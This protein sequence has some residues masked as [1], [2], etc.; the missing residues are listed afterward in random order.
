MPTRERKKT[1][2]LLWQPVKLAAMQAKVAALVTGGGGGGGGG[3]GRA[4]DTVNN[5]DTD[6][7]PQHR[8]RA[9]SR[10]LADV[11]ANSSPIDFLKVSLTHYFMA[12]IVDFNKKY[13][14]KILEQA[15]QREARQMGEAV[16]SPRS[17]Y[18]QW[19]K[20][21]TDLNIP[22]HAGILGIAAEY[23]H[24]T[25]IVHPRLLE[26]GFCCWSI[27][28]ARTLG[29]N[30]LCTRRACWLCLDM[31]MEMPLSEHHSKLDSFLLLF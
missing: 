26:A 23:G 6:E 16:L 13:A 19:E 10:V 30:L 5:V 17:R 14:R 18:H 1:V 20:L 25:E 7:A 4:V 15:K 11:N 31:A 22:S 21:S 12:T 27:L 29:Q 24:G 8:F 28:W 9:D 2:Q 3:G